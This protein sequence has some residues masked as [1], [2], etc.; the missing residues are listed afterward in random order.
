MPYATLIGA[1]EISDLPKFMYLQHTTRATQLGEKPH[2]Q[3]L[4]G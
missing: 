3:S 1:I 2:M 4:K